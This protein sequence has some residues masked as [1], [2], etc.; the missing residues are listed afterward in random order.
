VSKQV[1]RQNL[2]TSIALAVIT[3]AIGTLINLATEGKGGVLSW[4]A[5]AVLTLAV[6]IIP[7]LRSGLASS[8]FSLMRQRQSLSVAVIFF[9]LI[10]LVVADGAYLPRSSDMSRVRA[11]SFGKSQ[12]GPDTPSKPSPPPGLINANSLDL[13][14][15]AVSAR[16]TAA[17][18]DAKLIPEGLTV[19]RD[20]GPPLEFGAGQGEIRT[21]AKLRNKRASAILVITASW[22]DGLP[23]VTGCNLIQGSS[24]CETTTSRDGTRVTYWMRE[25]GFNVNAE[26]IFL[27]DPGGPYVMMQL[28]DEELSSNQLQLLS[29]ENMVSI[30]TLIART[31][32][33]SR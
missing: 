16:L 22:I 14:S 26:G 6:G 1:D 20:G 8:R 4:V 19:E 31:L 33:T 15:V 27:E 32:K 9:L 13:D 12:I 21:S 5:I 3:S 29:R 10:M 23:E 7:Y 25:S 2:L 30:A 11:D 24:W 17:L 18:R 28:F